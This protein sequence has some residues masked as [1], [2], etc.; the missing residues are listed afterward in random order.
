MRGRT[1]WREPTAG[2]ALPPTSLWRWPALLRARAWAG[3]TSTCR[4]SS[5][6]PIFACSSPPTRTRPRVR[7]VQ[8]RRGPRRFPP[9]TPPP[10]VL[11]VHLHAFEVPLCTVE[12]VEVMRDAVVEVSTKDL[13]SVLLRVLPPYVAASTM[14][15]LNAAAFFDDVEE[16]EDGPGALDAARRESIRH[17][18]ITWTAQF[19]EAVRQF[20]FGDPAKQFA[21]AHRDALEG[22]STRAGSRAPPAILVQPRAEGVTALARPA[23]TLPLRRTQPRDPRRAAPATGLEAVARAPAAPSRPRRRYPLARRWWSPPDRWARRW[24]GGSCLTLI[25]S[26]GVRCVL[27]L[28]VP[29]AFGMRPPGYALTYTPAFPASPLPPGCRASWTSGASRWTGGASTATP[30]S[31]QRATRSTSLCRAA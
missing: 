11:P 24:T 17:D 8:G 1:R 9:L 30:T 28:G 20:A 15:V 23:L 4:G 14:E 22:G 10:T 26:S 21:R 19:A 27:R 16:Q 25:A 7:A 12:R 31:S 5:S 3:T 6:S 29:R 18:C 2:E 13:R